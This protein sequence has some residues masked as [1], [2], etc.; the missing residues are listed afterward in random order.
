MAKGDWARVPVILRFPEQGPMVET[1]GFAGSRGDVY[2]EGQRF[3]PLAPSQ[4][5]FVFMHPSSTLHLLPMPM[6]LADAGLHVLC[7]ASR[8][9]KNDSALVMEK[10]AVDLGM[11]IRHA[12]EQL[13]YRRVVLVGWSGGGSLSLFYQAQ[14][15]RPSITHTP[16][17]DPY[18]LTRAGLQKADGVVFIAAH[19]SR[20]ETLTQWLDP[21][22]LDEA[23]PD[24]R[25]PELDIYGASCPNKPPF[26]PAFV[27]KFRQAQVARNRRI[28][29]WALGTLEQLRRR[30][31]GEMERGFV[32]HRTMCDVRWI[33]PAIEPNGRRPG[34]CYLGDPRIA[35]VAPAGLARFSSLRSW[36]SQWSYDKS[37][38]KGP[39]NAARVHDTPILQIENGADDAVPAS[40]NAII[41]GALATPDKEYVLIEGATHY[42]VNQPDKLERCVDAVRDWCVRKRLL[43]G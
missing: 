16:A 28:T 13:G 31:D 14:A 41:R 43:P 30:D 7:A 12:R 23:A 15:E 3:V 40:H 35:N 37:N 11:W 39:A 2:L 33:D 17:G 22:V 19:L 32:V 25:D 36:L 4:T 42:Y 1:Y 29:D 9:P 21:S 10:V 20:A 18:D 5:L 27:E 6:A 38:A 34:W 26:T 8:Y 24:A